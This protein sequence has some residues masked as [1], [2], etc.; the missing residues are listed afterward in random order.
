MEKTDK[1]AKK[2]SNISLPALAVTHQYS[3]GDSKAVYV[4]PKGRP[5]ELIKK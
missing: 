2:G 5:T 4:S 1:P 3:N